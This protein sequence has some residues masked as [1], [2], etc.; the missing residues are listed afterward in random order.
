M[1]GIDPTKK[2]FKR[3]SSFQEASN[4]YGT[5]RVIAAICLGVLTE[6]HAECAPICVKE[7]EVIIIIALLWIT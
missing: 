3:N 6:V 1:Q 4:S 7:V 2:R 5:V